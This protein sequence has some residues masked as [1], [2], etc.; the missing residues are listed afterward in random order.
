MADASS[1]GSRRDQP[2]SRRSGTQRCRPDGTGLAEAITCSVRSSSPFASESKCGSSRRFLGCDSSGV[3]QRHRYDDAE[4]EAADVREERH[5]ASVRRRRRATRARFDE[6]VDDPA[7]EVDPGRD[8]DEEDEHQRADVCAWVEND[9][10]AEDS[11]DRAAGPER[12]DARGG[13]RAEEQRDGGLRHRRGEAAGDVEAEVAE[14]PVRVL[15]VLAEDGEEEHVP[16]MW[17]QPP[18]MNMA[19]NQ[20]TAQGSGRWQALSTVQG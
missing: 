4:D 6:L 17:S 1:F 14:V 7:A 5:A 16:E 9:E 18:C 3:E 20:L 8:L 10:G 19:V 11:G 12:W 15:D 13:R 2:R